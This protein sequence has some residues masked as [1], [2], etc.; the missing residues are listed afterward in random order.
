MREKIVYV[1]EEHNAEYQKAVWWL[2]AM[3]Y[4]RTVSGTVY[5]DQLAE[6]ADY[7]DCP[8]VLRN[9]LKNSVN[10]YDDIENIKN[11]AVQ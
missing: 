3:N 4:I 7:F 9:K 8:D 11:I 5:V 2:R 10:V 6:L 1:A